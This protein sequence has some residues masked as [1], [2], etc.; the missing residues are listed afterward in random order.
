MDMEFHPSPVANQ[1]ENECEQHI[2]AVCLQMMHA[3]D[4][5]I[6]VGKAT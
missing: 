3:A 6:M 4:S 5:L 1:Q 2:A